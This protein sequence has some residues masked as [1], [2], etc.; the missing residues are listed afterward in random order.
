MAEKR[1]AINRLVTGACG[2]GRMFWSAET[3]ATR[4]QQWAGGLAG[5]AREREPFAD[6]SAS[7]ARFR[8]GLD[9]VRVYRRVLSADEIARLADGMR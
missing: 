1:R 4:A 9:D 6:Q 2:Q 5:A 3:S 7:V 8:G